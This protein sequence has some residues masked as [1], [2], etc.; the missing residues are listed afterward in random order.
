MVTVVA[1]PGYGKSTLLAQCMQESELPWIWLSCDPR[2]ATPEMLVSHIAAGLTDGFPGVASGLT[3]GGADADHVQLLANEI[4]ATIPD[5]FVIAFD[6]VHALNEAT[7]DGLAALIADLPPNVHLVLASRRNLPS[8]FG[9]V[10]AGDL[11]KIAE[12]QLTLSYDEAVQLL[13]DRDDALDEVQIGEVHE[14]TEGWVSGLLLA[15]RPETGDLADPG[16]TPHFDYLA[17]EV[18]GSLPEHQQHFLTDTAMLERFTPEL[19]AHVTGRDD[20]RELIDALRADHLFI[21]RLQG[22]WFRYHHLFEAFLRRRVEEHAPDRLQAIHARAGEAWEEAGDYQEAVRHYLSVGLFDEAAKA[23]DPVAEAMVATP[24]AETLAGWLARIPEEV[25]ARHPRLL[26]AHALLAYLQRQRD[27]AF[28]LWPAAIE[29]L[30]AANAHDAASAA[31]YRFQQGMLTYGINPQI[32]IASGE[33]YLDALDRSARGLGMVHLILG[34]AHAQACRPEEAEQHIAAALEVGSEQ[35]SPLLRPTAD[36]LRAFYMEFP[37][38]NVN[39]ALDLIDEALARLEPIEI[40]DANML[41]AFG[42]GFRVVIYADIGRFRKSL[43]EAKAVMDLSEA[44]GM[45]SAAETLSMWWRLL[46][47]AGLRDWESAIP[48]AEI[49]TPHST[50][51]GTTSTAYRVSASCARVAA[52]R[53]DEQRALSHIAIA[54]EELEAYGD[55]YD[56]PMSLCEMS[57][58][59]EETGRLKLA[60][61]LIEEACEFGERYQLSWYL[62]RAALISADLHGPGEI[63]D[64]RLR[65][66]IDFTAELD[67]DF[68]WSRRERPRA[69]PLL[70]HALRNGIGDPHGVARIAA[71]CGREVLDECVT[72][73]GDAHVEARVALGEAIDEHTDLDPSTLSALVS[74]PEP[75]VAAAGER[76][77][78]ILETR[79]RPPI[80]IESFGGLRLYRSGTRVPD[81]EFGRPKA[82]VLLGALICAGRSG[83]H[84]DKLLDEL[85]PDLEPSRGSRALDTTLHALRRTLDPLTSARSRGSMISRDGDVYRLELGEQDSWDA[86]DFLALADP[87]NEDDSGLERLLRA[88]SLWTSDFLPDFP[89]DE[90]AQRARSQLERS[91]SALLERLGDALQA[92]GRPVAAITRYQ[93]LLATDPEREAL[94]RALMKAYAAAGERALAL[95]QFHA[96]RATL[97]GSLGV[98]PSDETRELYASLL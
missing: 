44:L 59:A 96:C 61:E 48:I 36:M 27:D 16:E 30:I 46:A 84:R 7:L 41:R 50:S 28:R 52:A 80:R 38:G 25:R 4:V 98:E 57:L 60:R 68:L 15:T 83:V 21:V 91:R 55:S 23:L 69:A 71:A 5:D 47:Y 10:S 37:T 43:L 32:R 78:A 19:A 1:G 93:E 42:M 97:R 6:D 74:D 9:R 2:L 35:E 88:E 79:P 24:E 31:L 39:R 73:L 64:A 17:E 14:K 18:F 82:R 94:H 53:G 56:A 72:R 8:G 89:Y 26:M 86:A 33:K 81:A 12:R 63:G 49:A 22:Q 58:A 70:A 3:A 66:A 87:G 45:G 67:L 90:W 77:K 95:R 75:Q 65:Q 34:V 11:T 13:A 92:N 85:W 20:A 76:A 62:A 40:Q 51:G 54:R 29:A